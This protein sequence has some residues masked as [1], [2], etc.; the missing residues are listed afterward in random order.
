MT[1]TSPQ[2]YNVSE[3][4]PLD[5]DSQVVGVDNKCSACI[6]NVRSDIPGEIVA[7]NRSI[8]GFGG[9]KVW[10]VWMGTI[11]WDI[12]D[13]EGVTHTHIIPNS[14]YI[15]QGQLRLLSPQHWAQSRA[16]KDKTGGAG[17][18]TMAVSCKLFWNNEQVCKTIPI[19]VHGNNIAT[20]HL[21]TAYNAFHAY[22]A[23]TNIDEYDSDPLLQMEVESTIISDDDDGSE[24]HD[25]PSNKEDKQNEWPER[26]ESD[27]PR[28]FQL[29]GPKTPDT[30]GTPPTI[31]LDEEE[32]QDETAVAELLRHHHNMGHLSFTKVQEMAKQGIFPSRIAKCAVP[33]CSACQYAKATR[34]Q[35]HTKSCKN[36]QD[37]NEHPTKPGQC[38]SVDQLVSPAPGLI[39]Q[40]TRFITKQWYKY[41]TVYVDQYSRLSFVYLQCTA[42]AAE[43]LEGK[44]AFER[45]A[46]LCDVTINA[47]HTDNGIFKAREWVDNC[48]QSQQGLTFAGVGA[49]HANGKAE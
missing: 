11:K 33:I 47:Y 35:W 48:H 25:T 22:C 13:D 31:I 9:T 24:L 20:F 40:M 34:R 3:I 41:A 29:D 44:R 28:L 39:A 18:E 21:A 17:A 1:T 15:P 2:S 19:D 30:L 37:V 45:Y 43:T 27:K 14:Y 8:R 10:N 38:V 7:C 12:E 16:G 36:H 42:S 46:Q 26:D 6:T 4:P 49:H 32:R 23:A 5:T